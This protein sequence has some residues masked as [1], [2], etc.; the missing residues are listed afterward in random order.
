MVLKVYVIATAAGKVDSSEIV[1]PAW[2]RGDRRVR[3]AEE[4]LVELLSDVKPDSLP[5]LCLGVGPFPLTF[6]FDHAQWGLKGFSNVG[7]CGR[8]PQGIRADTSSLMQAVWVGF[9]SR[10][11]HITACLKSQ[12]TSSPSSPVRFRLFGLFVCLGPSH[13]HA[14]ASGSGCSGPSDY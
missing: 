8:V 10:S 12:Q 3:T 5:V 11:H 4:P 13:L 6:L 7:M 9:E 1:Q 14:V 2:V